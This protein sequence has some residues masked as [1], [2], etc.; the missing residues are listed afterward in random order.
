MAWHP[1]DE[2]FQSGLSLLLDEEDARLSATDTRFS[3]D[4]VNTGNSLNVSGAISVDPW[5]R[6]SPFVSQ[7]FR[8]QL[9]DYPQQ[10]FRQ[11]DY[12]QQDYYRQDY[13]QQERHPDYRQ[14]EYPPQDFRQ[15]DFRPQEFRPQDYRQ[16]EYR[17]GQPYSPIPYTPFTIPHTTAQRFDSRTDPR[18]STPEPRYDPFQTQDSGYISTTNL[19]PEQDIRRVWDQV[20]RQR[21]NASA[22]SSPLTH[23]R[24]QPI[25]PT[26]TQANSTYAGISAVANCITELDPEVALVLARSLGGVIHIHGVETHKA[27]T[28]IGLG[29]TK[30]DDLSDALRKLS[31]EKPIQQVADPIVK[32]I[33]GHLIS[34]SD[35]HRFTAPAFYEFP[36]CPAVHVHTPRTADMDLLHNLASLALVSKSFYAGVVPHLWDKVVLTSEHAAKSCL[37]AIQRRLQHHEASPAIWTTSLEMTALLSQGTISGL[38]IILKESNR[39]VPSGRHTVGGVKHIS[40]YTPTDCD[41]YLLLRLFDNTPPKSLDSLS[42]RGAGCGERMVS[43]IA[44]WCR[45]LKKLELIDCEVTD[46][47]VALILQQ[48]NFLRHLALRRCLRIGDGVFDGISG[49]CR[50]IE[51]LILDLSPPTTRLPRIDMK[52]VSNIGFNQLARTCRD[53]RRVIL[54]DCDIGDQA[55]ETL[56]HSC[57]DLEVVEISTSDK[58]TLALLQSGVEPGYLSSSG[59]LRG[60]GDRSLN[61]LFRTSQVLLR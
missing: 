41:E 45:N 50:K 48:A 30:N 13:R 59:S 52:G 27:P 25:P 38:N 36:P 7:E 61:A 33:V 6:T 14:Q 60:L 17:K 4:F 54:V 24:T 16:Q 57:R 31:I 29:R 1:N 58:M 10:E 39:R 3:R 26:Q 23:L 56:A 43:V 15:Q 55:L 37:E 2:T 35:A 11:Q 34:S 28:P 53:L 32:R 42:L 47:S 12:R 9:A 40:L 51:T 20:P 44:L 19:L 5:R 22:P 8:P 49:Y 18:I 46:P 21:G